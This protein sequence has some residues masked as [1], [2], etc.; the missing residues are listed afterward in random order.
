MAIDLILDGDNTAA[1]N[2]AIVP[3]EET[4][5]ILD[6]VER[7]SPEEKKQIEDFSK[8]IDIHLRVSIFFCTFAGKFM[9]TREMRYGKQRK[10][11]YHL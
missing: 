3:A 10:Q 2:T 4:Q 9:F 11:Y 7:L 5:K 8:K 1:S 6:E